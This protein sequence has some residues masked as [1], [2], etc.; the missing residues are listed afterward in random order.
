MASVPVVEDEDLVARAAE[1]D[2]AAFAQL[3]ERYFDRVHDLLS[4]MLRNRDD[5]EDAAQGTFT[6]MLSA[7][8]T[9]PP[10]TSFRAWLFTPREKHCGR[11]HVQRQTYGG[12]AHLR[13]RGR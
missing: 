1:S 4:R 6:K 8:P 11:P 13:N 12:H 9:R 2:Q 10:H 5:A 7:L 3:Y